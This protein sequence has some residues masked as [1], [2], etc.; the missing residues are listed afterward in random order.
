MKE[1]PTTP[2]L[3]P[4]NETTA[5]VLC[6]GYGKRLRD[7]SGE[8]TPKPLIPIGTGKLLDYSV[9]S[10]LEA[11]ISKI[12]FVVAY[13]GDMIISH[14][15]SKNLHQNTLLFTDQEK[16]DGIIKGIDMAIKEH[17]LQKYTLLLDADSI[18]E[19][20]DITSALNQHKKTR[21][22]TTFLVSSYDSAEK[23]YRIRFNEEGIAMDI[24][25]YPATSTEMPYSLIF[26]GVTICNSEAIHNSIQECENDGGWYE[27]L[28]SLKKTGTAMVGIQPIT[29]MNI[30]DLT[31]YR[32]GSEYLKGK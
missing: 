9:K 6:G 4:R 11:G 18:R 19:G 29:Y 16:P 3:E 20:L 7:V 2:E 28:T 32:K 14:L 23:Q 10:I 24:P 30:N 26:T 15:N 8:S 17:G 25:S 21:A 1:I 5:I 31:S 22:T 12:I 27:L 13:R